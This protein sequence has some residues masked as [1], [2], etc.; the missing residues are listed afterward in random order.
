MRSRT[1]TSALALS[2]GAVIATAMLAPA[3]AAAPA[4]G[5][6]GGGGTLSSLTIRQVFDCYNGSTIA[7]D[8]YATSTTLAPGYLPTACGTAA[9][10]GLQGL[11][12]AV[13][14]GRG[15][16]AFI[17][18]DAL[19]LVNG[20]PNAGSPN[21]TVSTPAT[22]PP[23]INTGS[24]L[25]R[26]NTYPYPG[27]TF[28]AGD[29]PLSSVGSSSL[30]T[31]ALYFSTTT[32]WATSDIVTSIAL[33]TTTTSHAVSYPLTTVGEAVQF[34]LF[35][36]PVSVAVNTTN[37]TGLQSAGT[38]VSNAGGAIQ[39]STAQV[40]AIF[41]GVVTDWSSQA[42]I[43]TLN[44]SGTVGYQLF[45]DDNVSV[46][47]GSGT[48]QAY[49]SS[50]TPIH[51]T[52]RAD[53]SGTSYIFTN[54]LKNN[55]V[56][57]DNGSGTTVTIGGTSYTVAANH[58][59]AIFGATSLPSTSFSTLQSLVSASNGVTAVT[60]WQ[61]ATGSGG[62]A[63]AIGTG[64]TSPA[65]PGAIGY[66]S[67]DFT[68][69]YANSSIIAGA[70]HSASVQNEAQRE[71]GT[72]HPSTSNPFIA[73]APAAADA[74]FTTELTTQVSASA[75]TTYPKWD[76]YQYTHTSA[77]FLNGKSILGIP[78]GSAAYPV[79]GTTYI[80]AYNCYAN[81]TGTNNPAIVDLLRWY[82]NNGGTA[83]I[84]GSNT[85]TA[86][87]TVSS[88]LTNNGFNSL[89][90]S[91]ATVLFNQYLSSTASNRISPVASHGS[92]STLVSPTT[93]C[94]GLGGA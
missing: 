91:L 11:Y 51:V 14:S 5:L 36:V 90:S 61:S 12:G 73:P 8:G 20:G 6:W 28:A 16:Q 38:T 47:G 74:A 2:V 32:G 52:F 23:F 69:P 40:C 53:G 45:S 84:T 93:A 64:S 27:L 87:G 7:N 22:K 78:S 30:T 59:A 58:Y 29:N 34:P 19:Q 60:Y 44:S 17:A 81:V 72:Y 82:Y 76:L 9:T 37:L 41:A 83:A 92:G 4:T 54:Y 63:A 55:C 1:A 49:A 13:G 85:V 43:T 68:T 25:A 79:I 70:P 62:V 33:S 48:A 50:S 42:P 56:A 26:F 86:N 15:Q 18:N 77:G 75:V 10:N 35:E 80:Y 88:V 3:N 94:S 46:T 31:N 24:G 65:T 89:N 71:A 39:L 67:A 66:L 57:L 21:S